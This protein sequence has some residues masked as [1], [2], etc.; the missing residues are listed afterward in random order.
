MGRKRISD[1]WIIFI[2]HLECS[3]LGVECQ[4]ELY[5]AAVVSHNEA[6]LPLLENHRVIDDVLRKL[7]YY[8]QLDLAFNNVKPKDRYFVLD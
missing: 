2:S 8:V 6:I 1:L 4:A 3:M 7:S 5:L